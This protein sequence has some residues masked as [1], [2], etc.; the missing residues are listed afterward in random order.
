MKKLFS[1]F[2]D[3]QILKRSGNFL[4]YKLMS[5]DPAALR[6][7]RDLN[8]SAEK[9]EKIGKEKFGPSYKRQRYSLIDFFI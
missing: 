4:A 6:A 9:L 7:L 2:K 3:R 8:E 1:I 5:R